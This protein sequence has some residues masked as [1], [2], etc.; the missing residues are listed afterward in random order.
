[1][2]SKPTTAAGTDDRSEAVAQRLQD[3]LNPWKMRLYFLSKLPSAWFWRLRVESC[4]ESAC[5]VSIPYGWRT[6]NPFRSTYFAA[7]SGAAE[8]STGL[9]AI[10]ALTG[11]GRVSMLITGLEAQF[12]KKADTRTFFTCEEGDALQAAVQT[13]IDSGE[14]QTVKVR[15]T[16]RNTAGEIVCELQLTWSFKQKRAISS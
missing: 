13:A 2:I 10:L 12:V 7:L 11:R 4:T 16:G 5:T 14:A 3:L 6:Q 8:L 15:S 9:L 1:M